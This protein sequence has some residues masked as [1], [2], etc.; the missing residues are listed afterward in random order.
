[1][2]DFSRK[3]VIIV[4]RELPSWQAMNTVAHVSGYISHKIAD[5]FDTGEYF[6]TKDNINHPRNSQY[7]FIILSAKPGQMVNLMEKV[8]KSSLLYHG[9]IRE[10]IETNDDNEIQAIL[11]T[12]TDSEIEYLGIGAFGENDVVDTLT[13]NYSLW[14]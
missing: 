12:K 9:F 6:V 3:M 7:P 5:T 14:K 2:Q 13:K 10:M 4:N 11:D 8:R 1:M